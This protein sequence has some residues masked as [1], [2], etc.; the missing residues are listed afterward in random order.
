M[1]LNVPL[2]LL[3]TSC[4]ILVF[5]LFY[6]LLLRSLPAHRLHRVYLLIMP[7]LALMIPAMSPEVL[8]V[9]TAGEGGE[10][11]QLF[12]T[13]F[14]QGLRQYLTGLSLSIADLGLILY[15]SGFTFLAFRLMD[16]LWSIREWVHGHKKYD[17]F[18]PL[19]ATRRLFPSSGIFLLLSWNKDQLSKEE[20]LVL[21]QDRMFLR[22][23]HGWETIWM[24]LMV[25][26][27]W[28]QPVLFLIR[29]ELI[30][31]EQQLSSRYI[32]A[33]L[34]R[35]KASPEFSEASW[36]FALIAPLV[37][38]LFAIFSFDGITDRLGYTVLEP[39]THRIDHWSRSTLLSFQEPPPEEVRY[40]AW[41]SKQIMLS[42]IQEGG[43]IDYEVAE[44]SPYF[45][46]K[47][48]SRLPG[49]PSG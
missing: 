42:P 40:L 14:P 25:M 18:S 33:R 1:G 16:R 4:C 8:P 12:G 30:R 17:L 29:R 20:L 6:R 23:W 27:Q 38:F 32:D 41:G 5:Y 48:Q 49:N 22:P 31:V 46:G 45:F 2:Y 21:E 43:W 11:L 15:F 7:L 36:R 37:F 44:I 10:V 28:F 3:E 26:I 19:H 9:H 47:L 35:P 34:G 24:E 13:S 39:L